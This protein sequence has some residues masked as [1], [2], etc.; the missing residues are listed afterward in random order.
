MAALHAQISQLNAS[1]SEA[2][3]ENKE[4]LADK[5]TLAAENKT[6]STKLAANR[7]AAASVESASAPKVPG[8]AVKA[9]GIRMMGT[10]EAAQTAQAAQLK[11]DLYGDLTGL[12]I[13]SVARKPEED[14]FDCIQTGRNGSK[15][16]F[17]T[18]LI[19]QL[20]LITLQ[21]FTSNWMRPTRKQLIV[22]MT[23]NAIMFLNWTQ[24][25]T[26]R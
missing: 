17:Y 3:K 6:L 8:S 19:F 9:G 2:K 10:A 15:F 22:T 4:L 23:R 24:A 16:M 20:L 11:E 7:T 21:L 1:L 13:M 5:K 25:E 12:I 18:P 26:N 14:V